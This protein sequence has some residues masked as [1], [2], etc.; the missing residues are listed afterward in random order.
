MKGIS[1]YKSD[2]SESIEVKECSSTLHSSKTHFHEELS[3]G[4]IHKGKTELTV[5]NTDYSMSS[6]DIIVI[7]P[8][9]NH[10]CTPL[11]SGNWD[12]K[13]YYIE[14][15]LYNGRYSDTAFKNTVRIFKKSNKA[16]SALENF[17]TMM[18]ETPSSD[19]IN[20]G[21]DLIFRYIFNSDYLKITEIT[22]E[23]INLIRKYIKDNF[24]DRLLLSRIEEKY[25]INKFT[26][27]REF[28]R[29]YNTTPAAY[30]I[31][32]KVNYAKKLLNKRNDIAEI[33][34]EAG[35]Y[36][37]PHFTREFKRAYGITPMEYHN[38]IKR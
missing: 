19:R 27:I 24:L 5:G 9:V 30:Q 17:E 14:S 2:I 28:K 29:N 26:L 22:P 10:K 32:L 20:K 13:M 6:G 25:K 33:S 1:F 12:F 35:F 7:Y 16:Y 15:R 37:Q 36:D 18:E 31:E 3:I 4:Y 21:L 38:S 11:D 23:K 8:F 34:L